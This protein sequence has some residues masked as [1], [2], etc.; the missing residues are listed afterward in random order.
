[1]TAGDFILGGQNLIIADGATIS[2]GNSI[3]FH[4]RQCRRCSKTRAYRALAI[5]ILF[6]SEAMFTRLLHLH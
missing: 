5:P 2:G 4:S 1:M 3:S 6:L